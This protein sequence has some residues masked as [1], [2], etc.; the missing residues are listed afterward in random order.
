MIVRKCI[1]EDRLIDFVMGEVRD[2]E[3]AGIEEHI[4]Q[5]PECGAAID[6][7]RRTLDIAALDRVPEPEPAYW[8]HFA[9][10]VA[11]R[12]RDR[13]ERRKRRFRLVLMPG[14]AAAAACVLLVVVF[15]RTQVEP[16]GDVENIIAEINTSVVTE[17]VLL[18]SGVDALLLGQFGADANVLDD[19][20]LETGNIGEIVSELDKDEEREL[21]NRLNSLMELRGSVGSHARKG[22]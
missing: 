7:L 4:R 14:L 19:Y 1:S 8:A 9:G 6:S 10:N 18:E 2:D 22:C 13:A 21:I 17:Q 15:T 5:C 16:V 11:H 12:I 20:L 3:A